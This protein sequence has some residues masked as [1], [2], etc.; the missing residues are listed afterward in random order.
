MGKKRNSPTTPPSSINITSS[1][2]ST[3]NVLNVTSLGK[4]NQI[5][6]DDY[7]TAKKEKVS[8]PEA[9]PIITDKKT[10]INVLSQ[11]IHLNDK[12]LLESVFSAGLKDPDL[13]NAT[14]RG[15]EPSS[16][17]PFLRALEALISESPNRLKVFVPWVSSLLA[18]HT[19]SLLS[20]SSENGSALKQRLR[21]L[22]ELLESRISSRSS[23][24]RLTGKLDL[25]LDRIEMRLGSSEG[26]AGNILENDST[27]VPVQVYSDRN[28]S[29]AEEN[30]SQSESEMLNHNNQLAVQ[31]E[32]EDQNDIDEKEQ[33]EEDSNDEEG[34]SEEE[35]LSSNGFSEENDSMEETE[36]DSF[37]EE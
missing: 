12:N 27:L 18:I 6:P 37:G 21:P 20:F 7:F 15:L 13:I 1:H 11:A 23:L 14:V 34:L 10:L 30:D 29:E 4:N 19:S 8:I 35:E 3:E 33:S 5:S 17:L 28:D 2:S 16:A 26:S 22:L 32:S 36:V 31:S 25:L 9:L 24:E